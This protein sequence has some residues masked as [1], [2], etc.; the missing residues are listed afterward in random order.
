MAK[1]DLT[2]LMEDVLRKFHSP[3]KLPYYSQ[4][5]EESVKVYTRNEV[6]ILLKKSPNTITKFIK[7]KDLHA[8]CLNGVYYINEK[9]L[10]KFLNSKSLK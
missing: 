6:A 4:N 8:S 10:Q 2:A 5:P 7:K 3:D 9:A 1:D